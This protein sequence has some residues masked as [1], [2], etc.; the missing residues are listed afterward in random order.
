MHDIEYQDDHK[1]AKKGGPSEIEDDD[2]NDLI[3]LELAQFLDE[4]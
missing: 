3:E 2:N 1:S 4:E